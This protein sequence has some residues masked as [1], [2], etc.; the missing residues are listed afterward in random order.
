[1]IPFDVHHTTSPGRS[2]G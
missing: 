2:W 1:M